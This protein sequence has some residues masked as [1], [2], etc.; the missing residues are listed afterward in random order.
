MEK[1]CK[2]TARVAETLND[3][4]L[5]QALRTNQFGVLSN[6]D[7]FD[8]KCKH[9]LIKSRDTGELHAC[10]RFMHFGGG[11]DIAGSYSAQFYNLQRLMTYGRPMVEL[12]RFCVR[13]GVR[14]HELLRVAWAYLTR[15]VD[16]HDIALIF[17]CSSFCGTDEA[18]Y[19]DAF[20]LLKDRYL[21]PDIWRPQAL[22]PEVFDFADRLRDYKPVLKSANL[23]MPPLLRTYLGMGG[24]VSDHAVV[25][26]S[27]GTLH[28]FTGVEVKAIPASRARLLRM[29]AGVVSA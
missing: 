7:M 23:N 28:V 13:G 24:W 11:G 19:T 3:V 27:M 20:A 25:D 1:S 26:R 17:G 9:V 14:D 8:A 5:A 21:A 18:K 6:V 2:Y 29:D 4:R 15:Y 12:G 16:A 10:F 22:A